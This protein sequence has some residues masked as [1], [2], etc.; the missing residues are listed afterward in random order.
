VQLG[1]TGQGIS[2]NNIQH[3]WS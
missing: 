1:I 2:D 3:R